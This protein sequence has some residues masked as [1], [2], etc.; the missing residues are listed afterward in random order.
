MVRLQ[1]L[2]K[3][4]NKT[5]SLINSI[6]LRYSSRLFYTLWLQPPPFYCNSLLQVTIKEHS[7]WLDAT[8]QTTFDWSRESKCI[9]LK[10][11]KWM[12]KTYNQQFD[13]CP[14]ATQC[15]FDGVLYLQM[16]SNKTQ[17]YIYLIKAQQCSSWQ[18]LIT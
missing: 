10:Y 11:S 2:M 18:K 6:N 13:R 8:A 5:I 3:S 7:F 17:Q 4:K 12:H 1:V 16:D 9:T 14:K 15:F